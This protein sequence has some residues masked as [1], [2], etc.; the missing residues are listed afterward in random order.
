MDTSA[1]VKSGAI[2]PTRFPVSAGGAVLGVGVLVGGGEVVG[3]GVSTATGTAMVGVGV[4][5]GIG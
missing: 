5:V 3:V 1:R 2:L 4:G